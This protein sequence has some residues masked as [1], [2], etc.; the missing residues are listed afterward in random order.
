MDRISESVR[1]LQE[2]LDREKED[3]KTLNE[4]LD[5]SQQS[6]QENE[7]EVNRKNIE[8]EQSR[9]NLSRLEIDLEN[10]VEELSNLSR[11]VDSL[12]KCLRESE[13][14][15]A[16]TEKEIQSTKDRERSQKELNQQMITYQ[17]DLQ[18]QI[19]F[20]F[21]HCTFLVTKW[22]QEILLDIGDFNLKV[23]QSYFLTITIC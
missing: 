19:R 15:L 9:E 20:V 21:L 10:R 5:K 3:T 17:K 7:E 18:D 14:K 4:K 12:R 8:L 23:N 22:S 11:E 13:T 2:E 16:E 6:L 1:R